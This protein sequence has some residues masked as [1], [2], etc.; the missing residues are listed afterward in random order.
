MS[1]K[2][3]TLILDHPMNELW[4]DRDG[5]LIGCIWNVTGLKKASFNRVRILQN[6]TQI[7]SLWDVEEIKEQW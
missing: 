2:G 6:G 1:E 4:L 3:I 7:G 5:A